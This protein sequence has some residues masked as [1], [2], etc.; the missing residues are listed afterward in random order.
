MNKINIIDNKVISNNIKDIYLNDFTK[1][2][3]LNINKNSLF[4]YIPHNVITELELICEYS[5][6]EDIILVI[7]KNSSLKTFE[8]KTGPKLEGSITYILLDN[9]SL[10]INKFSNITKLNEEININLNGIN[11]QVDCYFSTISTD[12]NTYNISINH[13]NKKTKSNIINRGV[14]LDGSSLTFNLVGTI[15]NDM[16]DSILNQDSK[17]IVMGDNNS[18]IEPKLFIYEDKVEAKHS[19]VIGRF[20][21]EELFYLK[22]RGLSEETAFQLLIKGFLFGF[23]NITSEQKYEIIKNII[24]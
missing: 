8:F 2:N 1:C 10:E 7:D 15:Y 17:I 3:Y 20:R 19:A 5:N 9:A 23:L 6:K 12:T 14:S 16:I 18:I 13:N 21:D 11:S 4:I 22:S 24:N